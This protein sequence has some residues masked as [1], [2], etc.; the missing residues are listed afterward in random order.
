[1]AAPMLG[2][3]HP[4]SQPRERR[5]LMS[6]QEINNGFHHPWVSDFRRH[7]PSPVL[8]YLHRGLRVHPIRTAMAFGA[9]SRSGALFLRVSPKA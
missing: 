4:N 7:R 9:R 6:Y 2:I 5:A 8:D 3:L 1:M